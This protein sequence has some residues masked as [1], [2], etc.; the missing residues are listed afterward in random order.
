MIMR[1]VSFGWFIRY[2]HAN[3]ASFFFI[4]VYLH[5]ARGLYYGSYK[6]PRGQLWA[7]GVIIFLLMIITAF[8]GFVKHSPKSL[9]IYNKLQSFY[10]KSYSLFTS[11]V[12]LKGR[13]SNNNNKD[14]YQKLFEKLGIN[15]IYYFD[16]LDREETKQL[17]N[18]TVK[19]LSGI[20]MILNLETKAYY[21]GSASTNRFYARFSNHLIYFRGNKILKLA[22]KKYG[23]NKFL[24]IILELFPE[25]INKTNNEKLIELEDTYLKTYLPD[26]NILTEAGSSFGYKH[27][28]L[29]RQKM[30]ENFSEERRNFI[31]N[32]NK[33]KKLSEETIKKIRLSALNR[34]P[35][36]QESRLKCITNT[37]KVFIMKNNLIN[38]NNNYP[39]KDNNNIVLTFSSLKITANSLNCSYKTIQRSIVLGYIFIPDLLISYYKNNNEYKNNYPYNYD[40]KLKSSLIKKENTTKYLIIKKK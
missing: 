23:L 33:N 39:E 25:I 7:I 14:D 1:D 3:G 36:S 10:F 19:D 4:F 5:M 37:R 26:Y 24:F 12:S 6:S 9:Y 27:T 40:K 13:S 22:V 2:A 38:E 15:P 17:I 21:I 28:E 31:R 8:L 30:R 35:F 20:Y 18:K 29:T 34:K 11:N 16:N 32:L